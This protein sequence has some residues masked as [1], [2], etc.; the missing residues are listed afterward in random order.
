M[1]V[2]VVYDRFKR[3]EKRKEE[4]LSADRIGWGRIRSDRRYVTT[5]H[6]HP[7]EAINKRISHRKREGRQRGYG[8]RHSMQN[9]AHRIPES[10]A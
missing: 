9:H 2:F 1:R 5:C 10:L 8:G 6:P 7:W 4:Q 3:K